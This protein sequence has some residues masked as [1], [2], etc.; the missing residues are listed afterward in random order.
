MER[1]R[2][3]VISV[4]V[5]IA[6]LVTIPAAA[7]PVGTNDGQVKAVAEPI[8]DNLLA[9]FNQGNY[10]KYSQDFDDTLRKA[11]SEKKFQ[12]VREDLLK[13]LGTFKSKKYL[14]FLNQE[15]YT[16]ALFKGEFAATQDDI[17]I[18]LILAKGQDKVV[19]AGLWFQ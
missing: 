6:L 17:L 4:L 3:K 2:K 14:G 12:Q 19:V 8:L 5:L 7:A 1:V 9:G 15:G 13:K 10:V 16:I 11:I 18:K